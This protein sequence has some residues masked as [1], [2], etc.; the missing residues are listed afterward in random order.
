MHPYNAIPPVE[1]EVRLD[2]KL[3]P[4]CIRPQLDDQDFSLGSFRPEQASLVYA[5][6]GPYLS[7]CISDMDFVSLLVNPEVALPKPFADG[8]RWSGEMWMVGGRAACDYPDE[9]RLFESLSIARARVEDATKI[10]LKAR[11]GPRR[12]V[13]E[14]SISM[15]LEMWF[16]VPDT[17]I[18]RFIIRPEANQLFRKLMVP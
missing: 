9:K 4:A 3:L 7:I 8:P 11:L 13:G 12:D 17:E 16:I 10:S 5:H 1:S 6:M 2:G 14:W 18:D 15:N